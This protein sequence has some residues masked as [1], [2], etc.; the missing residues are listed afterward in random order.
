[1]EKAW[2]EITPYKWRE[3]FTL[4]AT[5]F[6]AQFVYLPPAPMDPSQPN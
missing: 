5:G 1:M 6:W 3:K 2:S 4:L